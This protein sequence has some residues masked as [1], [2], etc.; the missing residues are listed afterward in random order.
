MAHNTDKIIVSNRSVLLKK[1]RESGL[2]RIEAEL[3]E[4][5]TADA[6]RGIRSKL[7]YLDDEAI[8]AF[9]AKPV[10]HAD[11]GRQNKDASTLSTGGL[12]PTTP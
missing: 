3:E 10:Q 5:M 7:I 9:R 11:S 6:K 1:Y 4:L 2:R 8:R 12:S